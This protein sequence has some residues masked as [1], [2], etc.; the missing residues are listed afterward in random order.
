MFSNNK[1]FKKQWEQITEA[2]TIKDY[3]EKNKEKENDPFSKDAM[4][5]FQK[6]NDA[7]VQAEFEA[8]Q[9]KSNNK[10]KTKFKV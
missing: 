10:Q 3:N 2:Q 5:K 6:E 7:R 4:E 8:R 1:D 9:A